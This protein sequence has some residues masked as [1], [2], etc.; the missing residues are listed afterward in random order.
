MP[1]A[2]RYGGRQVGLAQLPGARRTAAETEL[3]TGAELSREKSRTAQ[4]AARFGA[5][6]FG[7]TASAAIEMAQAEKQRADET[8]FLEASNALTKRMNDWQFDPEKGAYTRRGKDALDLPNEFGEVF[9]DAVSEIGTSMKNPQQQAAWSKFVGQQRVSLDLNVQRHVF[10]EMRT[11]QAG[12]AASAILNARDT[13]ISNANDPRQVGLYLSNGEAAIRGS[14]DVMGLGPEQTK[15]AV[16]ELRSSVHEGVIGRLL[17][18]G[19][20]SAAKAY[21]EGNGDQLRGEANKRV[22]SA[23]KEGT[24][25]EEAQNALGKILADPSLD[26]LAKQR[27]KARETLTGE[28]EDRVLEGLSQEDA[29]NDEAK[30]ERSQQMMVNA[31]NSIERSGGKISAVPP[32]DWVQMSPQEAAALREYADNLTK[33][34]PIV[35]DFATQYSLKLMAVEKPDEFRKV[36]LTQYIN[37]MSPSDLDEL[38]NIQVAVIKGDAKQAEKQLNGFMTQSQ[39]VNDVMIQYNFNPNAKPDTDEGR[40]VAMVRSMLDRRVEATQRAT[41]K[42][43]SNDDIRKTLTSILSESVEVKG[44]L[45]GTNKKPLAKLDISDVGGRRPLLEQALNGVGRPVDDQSLVNLDAE[46]RLRLGPVLDATAITRIPKDDVREIAAALTRDKQT[47]T[48]DAIL[49]W[50]LRLVAAG[51]R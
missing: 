23:M 45:W 12:E 46:I 50:Y 33:K 4:V 42:E 6:V 17:A 25:R 43:M 28:L 20:V 11:Y 8:A 13:A 15:Q 29:I 35:T 51:V 49:K 41:G 48:P 44:A 2:R 14:A 47:P 3:S 5:Q 39:T 26:T 40:A 19:K 21:F 1:V 38:A 24:V 30:R 7:V 10:Q 31:K 32:A 27:A 22:E 16:E 36:N 34:K 9:D 37:K 18:Q